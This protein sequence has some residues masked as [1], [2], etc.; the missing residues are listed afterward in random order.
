MQ[1][2]HL[3]IGTQGQIQEFWKGGGG[4]GGSDINNQQGEGGVPPPARSAE[5]FGGHT[6]ADTDYLSIL[7]ALNP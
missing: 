7:K 2:Y 3:A 5:A 4:G 1:V 6:F